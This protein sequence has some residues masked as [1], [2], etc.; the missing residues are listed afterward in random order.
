M[1]IKSFFEKSGTPVVLA[2]ELLI[3]TTCL[4]SN[5][6]T[7]NGA[8]RALY[9]SPNGSDSNPGTIDRPFLTAQHG[10]DS[11]ACGDTLY[12]RAGTYNGGI[13]GTYGRNPFCNSW[14]SPLT[15]QNYQGETV[16]LTNTY[17]QV[18]MGF[19]TDIYP[20]SRDMYMILKGVIFDAATG[21]G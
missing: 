19:A 15:I 10:Y 11:M 17:Q 8:P 21:A 16:I 9:V 14:T 7:V 3:A 5:I 18:I 2:L 12:L 1:R 4:I 20:S 6:K 13:G